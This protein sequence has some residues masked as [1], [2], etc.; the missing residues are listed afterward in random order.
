MREK[1]RQSMSWLHTWSGLILG[2]LIFVIFFTGTL[3][4]FRHEITH[5]MQPETH[6]SVKFDP[7]AVD[8][9]VDS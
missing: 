9:A 3:S 8:K 4:Y 1:F 2:W 5:W 6:G 7:A